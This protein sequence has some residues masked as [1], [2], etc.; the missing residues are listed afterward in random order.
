MREINTTGSKVTDVAVTQKIVDV[1]AELE[2]IR[3]QVQNI[4]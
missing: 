2:K 1:K 4:E 3:E